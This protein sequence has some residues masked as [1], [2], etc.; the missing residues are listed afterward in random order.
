M[1]EISTETSEEQLQREWR[2]F[3]CSKEQKKA[4]IVWIVVGLFLIEKSSVRVVSKN[5]REKEKPLR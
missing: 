1:T 4:F 2:S 3:R 5:I